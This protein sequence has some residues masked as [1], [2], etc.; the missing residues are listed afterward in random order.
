MPLIQAV[1]ALHQLQR[2]LLIQHQAKLSV[3]VISPALGLLVMIVLV[4]TM[5][6]E[7]V[8][9]AAL[10]GVLL[11]LPHVLVAMKQHVSQV[12]IHTVVLVHGLAQTVQ[13]LM[14]V[15]AEVQVDV[16]QICLTAL[17][18]MVMNEDAQVNQDVLSLHLI[19]VQR[20]WMNE[21]VHELDVV[22]MV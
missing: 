13:A 15:R 19:L 5:K 12:M 3:K 8:L 2:V 10:V 17:L 16:V 11:K 22:G 1:M 18:L 21:V 9:V 6:A 20:K 14:K 7:W 4:I